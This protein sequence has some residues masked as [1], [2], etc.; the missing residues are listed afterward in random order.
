M[1]KD[2]EIRT[3]LRA[4]GIPES[5]FKKSLKTEGAEPLRDMI[6]SGALIRGPKETTGVFIHPSRRAVPEA[7]KARVVTYL[8]AKELFLSGITVYCIPLIRLMDN[9]RGSD[10]TQEGHMLEKVRMVV[11]TDFF[12]EGAPFPFT[13]AEAGHLR[14][15]VRSRFEEG[16][17]VSFLSDT[18]M[19]RTGAWWPVGFLGQL[20]GNTVPYAVQ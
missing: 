1:N 18:P 7:T 17:G 12:E 14:L 11:V 15:W 13:A 9:L 10:F 20:G 8:L 3:G 19:E 6:T 16:K 2:E 4:A 5:V